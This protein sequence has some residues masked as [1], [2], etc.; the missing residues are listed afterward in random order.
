MYIKEGLLYRDDHD[1]AGTVAVEPLEDY[2][3]KVEFCTGEKV[4]FDMSPYI[5]EP[6][7][8]GLKNKGIF[9]SVKPGGWGLGACWKNEDIGLDAIMGLCTIYEN[10]YHIKDDRK[11]VIRKRKAAV[12]TEP[13]AEYHEERWLTMRDGATTIK[14]YMH[15]WRKLSTNGIRYGPGFQM[16]TK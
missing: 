4:I 13:A 7:F 15:K 3:I 16:N 5:D 11:P 8:E 2:K 10:G 14:N 9:N 1:L 12:S 6:Y